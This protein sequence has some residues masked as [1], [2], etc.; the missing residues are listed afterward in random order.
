MKARGLVH[1]GRDRLRESHPG[2]ILPSEAHENSPYDDE[3]RHEAT[4]E[5][6][7]TTVVVARRTEL[8]GTIRDTAGR[9]LPD[10]QLTAAQ[11]GNLLRPTTRSDSKGQ[12]LIPD[13]NGAGAVAL[14]I[15]HSEFTTLKTRLGEPPFSV[16]DL[17]LEPL[18]SKR[19]T[20]L[21]RG[22]RGAPIVGGGAWLYRGVSI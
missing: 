15:E 2:V 1:A 12:F 6:P 17:E 21:V 22:P 4:L 10:C 7:I 11:R 13:L 3:Y 8:H 9:A 20:G 5:S 14:R 18:P 19:I 16:L